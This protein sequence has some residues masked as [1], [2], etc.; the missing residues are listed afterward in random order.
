MSHVSESPSAASSL[1]SFSPASAYSDGVACSV[2][3]VHNAVQQEYRARQQPGIAEGA[4]SSAV[5]S[6]L[7]DKDHLERG[8]ADGGAHFN[9]IKRS[10]PM[11]ETHHSAGDEYESRA[12]RSAKKIQRKVRNRLATLKKKKSGAGKGSRRKAAADKAAAAKAVEAARADDDSVGSIDSK[13]RRGRR[14][15]A[16]RAKP[17]AHKS[18]EKSRSRTADL[19]KTEIDA[20]VAL[21]D[22]QIRELMALKAGANPSRGRVAIL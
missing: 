21:L 16:Y 1:A 17:P 11:V 18:R 14:E 12:L 15:S 22:R 20:K 9:T 5:I 2:R 7:S 10:R 6:P 3:K 8:Q 4:E 13:Q 19:S